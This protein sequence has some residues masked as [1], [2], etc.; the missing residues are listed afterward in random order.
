M[1]ID[2]AEAE[3]SACLLQKDNTNNSESN[4]VPPSNGAIAR[5][6]IIRFASVEGV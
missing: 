6:P 3:S 5:P 1:E 4:L 2:V